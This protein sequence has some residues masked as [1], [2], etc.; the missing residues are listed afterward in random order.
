MRPTRTPFLCSRH[1]EVPGVSAATLIPAKIQN[2][3]GISIP[4]LFDVYGLKYQ[5]F[6]KGNLQST[7]CFESFDLKNAVSVVAKSAEEVGIGLICGESG[8]GVSFI[9]HAGVE[10]LPRA[11]YEV[12][13]YG[14]SQICPRDFYKEVCRITKA[15][16]DGRGRQSMI[17]AIRSRAQALHDQG[18][19]L[20]LVLD[21]A[22]NIPEL[23]LGD[24]PGLISADYDLANHGILILCGTEKVKSLLRRYGSDSFRYD[25]S[26]SY[27]CR[28]LSE[29]ELA[30]YV[31]F[32]L[33]AAGASPDVLDDA[34][35]RELYEISANGNC[36]RVNNLMRI[37]L[38]IGAQHNR[39][40]ID[41]DVLR[42]A[43]SVEADVL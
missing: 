13:Y 11:Q 30:R 22:E 7:L 9:T 29:E 17:T 19:H 21:R 25:I 16:P 28:G 3:G 15:N 1:N 39:K 20:L 24:L 2:Q 42:S 26:Y 6:Q 37:A 14:V 38:K 5:P 23:V 31:R 4:S 34:V 8:T 35:V 18:R 27:K 43:A 12:C 33:S 41:V 40:T 36:K 10:R 32:K